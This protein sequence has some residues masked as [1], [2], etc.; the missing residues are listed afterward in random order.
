MGGGANS[1]YDRNPNLLDI[2]KARINGIKLSPLDE[3]RL[4]NQQLRRA[5]RM[6][7][8]KTKKTPK[9]F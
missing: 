4:R 6:Y 3:E 2:E 5:R 1:F 8:K 7:R 9:N